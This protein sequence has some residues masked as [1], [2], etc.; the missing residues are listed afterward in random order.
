MVWAKTC[1]EPGVALNPPVPH[2]QLKVEAFDRRLAD[3]RA[4]V[5]AD[6]DDPAPLAQHAEPAEDGEYVD[7]R[8][9]DVLDDLEAAALGVRDVAID[10]G[11]DDQL[12]LVGTG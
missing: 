11:A 3:D 5:G 10:A 1:P 7:D 2:P 6:G 8:L 12:A 9:H 4:G